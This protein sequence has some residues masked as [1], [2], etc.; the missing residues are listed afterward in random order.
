VSSAPGTVGS[1]RGE[2]RS[3]RWRRPL[4]AGLL[5]LAVLLLVLLLV[6]RAGG[7]VLATD[8]VAAVAVAVI[9]GASRS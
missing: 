2:G 6:D 4:L 3:S 7:T 1:V 8:A 9:V 5:A